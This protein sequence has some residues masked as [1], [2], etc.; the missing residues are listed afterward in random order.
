MPCILIHVL[1]PVWIAYHFSLIH[2]DHVGDALIFCLIVVHRMPIFITL[3]TKEC[4]LWKM[5]RNEEIFLKET[6]L[7]SLATLN[8]R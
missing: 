5:K 2:V 6:K 3:T 8:L 4:L 7:P 1:S